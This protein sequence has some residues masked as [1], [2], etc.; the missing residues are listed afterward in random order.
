[1]P[2]HI[3]KRQDRKGV[4]YLV[5][6]RLIRSLGTTVKRFAEHR[7]DQYIKG[8]FGFGR[9]ITVKEYFDSWIE[10][11]IEPMVRRSAVRDYRQHFNAY[12]LPT[13]GKTTLTAL[14]MRSV[15]NLRNKMISQGL[16]V[17][18]TRNVIV[19]SL[20]ALWRDAMA[21][22]LVDHMPFAGLRWPAVDRRLPEPFTHEERGKVLTWVA[23][24]LTF[25]YPFV[26]FQFSTGCRPSESTALR[27]SDI[28][29]ERATIAIQRSRHL[30]ANNRTKTA[31][32]WRII[33]VSR[34]LIDVLQQMRLPWHTDND[35]VFYNKV[36]ASPLDANEWMRIY[37]HHV[38]EGAKVEHR[39]FY[40]TRHTS[41]TEAVKRGDNLLAIAQYH[42]TSVSMIERNY[43][44]A[45]TLGD[46]TKIKPDIAKSLNNMVVPTGLEAVAPL[47]DNLRQQLNQAV[48]DAARRRKVG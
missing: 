43:C 35:A 11:K 9:G 15:E 24:E 44:G 48:R 37:W 30:R 28:S 40:A 8:K 2:P 42:G 38:C 3:K 13:L 46:Q 12:V 26:L 34:E 33:Q 29:V 18:T 27:W 25:Y 20:R 7:L 22:K 45:L 41:I 39:K 23:K 1:V 6:G 14:D 16:S 21:D 4:Y 10:R 19:G 17:K 5:D 32:S 47:S 31:A 36:S